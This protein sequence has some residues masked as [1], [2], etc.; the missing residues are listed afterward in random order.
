M[1]WPETAGKWMKYYEYDPS[2]ERLPCRIENFV[3]YHDKMKEFVL[4][5]CQDLAT[6]LFGEEAAI[7][8][9]K[10]NFKYP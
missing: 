6:D 9:E 1:A 4:G 3:V 5:Y 8:K 7:Y 10:I 2:G